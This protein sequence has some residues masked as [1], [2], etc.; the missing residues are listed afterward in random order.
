MSSLIAVLDESQ[1]ILGSD[2]LVTPV[3]R[4]GTGQRLFG[5]K[6]VYMPTMRILIAASGQSG[7]LEHLCHH[8]RY[9]MAYPGNR[10]FDTECSIGA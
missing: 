4:N 5:S 7:L 1:V 2:T 9:E 3:G 6:V 8:L 10:V